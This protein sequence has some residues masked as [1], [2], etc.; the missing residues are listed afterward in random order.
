MRSTVICS[1]DTLS[2][3]TPIALQSSARNV[4]QRKDKST[5]NLCIALRRA[6][7][8]SAVCAL[9]VVGANSANAGIV[10]GPTTQNLFG[11]LNG[12]SSSSITSKLNKEYATWKSQ[13]IGYLNG[14]AEVQT[15]GSSST[16]LTEGQ[17]YGLV[18]AVEM[19]DHTL[20]DQLYSF[21]QEYMLFTATSGQY[22]Y[23]KGYHKWEVTTS[24]GDLSA[25]DFVAPDGEEWIAA[26][27]SLAARR[28]GTGSWHG[29]WSGTI[30]YATEAQ[31]DWH[32]AMYPQINYGGYYIDPTSS[33]AGYHVV[34]FGPYNTFTDPSYIVPGFYALASD[35]VGSDGSAYSDIYGKAHTFLQSTPSNPSNGSEN[36]GL[37]PDYAT[38]SG[39]P[40]QTG[41]GDSYGPNFSYDAFRT[42][43]NMAIDTG[44]TGNNSGNYW[45]V[46][47]R[48][49]DQFYYY[50]NTVGASVGLGVGGYSY[51]QLITGGLP[52]GLAADNACASE[53]YSW[54]NTERASFT[55]Q[56]WTTYHPSDY[57]D[58]CLYM[59]GLLVC[60][61]Q[62]RNSF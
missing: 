2:V 11:S 36:W 55:N 3:F 53:L 9:S 51:G 17:G 30:N 18:I 44:W 28:W 47:A 5:M 57:Y 15:N 41:G 1:H 61:G 59:L 7:A 6:A 8:L 39:A 12:V 24:G 46:A 40:Y 23:A 37:H 32:D 4:A 58:D 14:T 50:G 48:R 49:Q 54:S 56:L 29:S 33:D 35:T 45:Q 10:T 16:V 19:N 42:T 22:A 34:R 27:L 43:M 38:W 62:F 20:F 60:G 13:R 25:G 31:T 52:V 26:G 21:A